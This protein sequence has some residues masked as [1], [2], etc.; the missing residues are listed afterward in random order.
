MLGCSGN[1]KIP[2]HKSDE[3]RD[4]SGQRKRISNRVWPDFQENH[5]NSHDT[6]RNPMSD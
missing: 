5:E 4:Y 2:V 6:R 1:I 3:M